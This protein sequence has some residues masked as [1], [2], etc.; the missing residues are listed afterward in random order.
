MTLFYRPSSWARPVTDPNDEIMANVVRLAGTKYEKDGRFG[1]FGVPFDGA[2]IGRRGAAAGPN[3]IRDE[4]ALLKPW[5]FGR[6]LVDVRLIDWGNVVVPKDDVATAHAAVA[7]AASQVATQGHFPIALGG[8]HSIT[9]PL[10]MALAGT[11]ETGAGSGT[12]TG[13]GIGIVNLDAHLDVRDVHEGRVTSGTPF[14][15]LLEAGVVRPEN[16][17]EVGVRDFAT[18]PFYGRK[19]EDLGV[20]VVTAAMARDEG[21]AAVVEDAVKRAARGT[22]GVYLSVDLDVLDQAHGPG[23]SAPTPD[24][25]TSGELL[26][27]IR[28]A[29]ASGK[30]VGADF[31]EV[32]PELDENA[33]TARAAAFGVLTLLAGMRGVPR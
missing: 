31:V 30:L 6:G 21:V 23:V 3:A 4:L 16:L 24:G 7:K 17:V 2:V 15:R 1:L 13:K 28:A 26:A 20:G 5:T 32:A 8:D 25:F 29:A 12:G 27:A 11:M 14:G 22:R 10:V 33:R 9:F 18:S 19:V